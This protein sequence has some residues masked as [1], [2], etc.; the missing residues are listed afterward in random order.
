M[1]KS[2]LGVFTE[3]ESDYVDKSRKRLKII[4]VFCTIIQTG[5][6][7]CSPFIRRT[8]TA[9]LENYTYT[10]SLYLAF[11]IYLVLVSIPFLICRKEL[12]DIRK[13]IRLKLFTEILEIKEKNN[14]VQI[15]VN[16]NSTDAKWIYVSRMLLKYH[17]Y[18]KDDLIVGDKILI[19]I[20]P[21]SRVCIKVKLF[22]SVAYFNR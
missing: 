19:S 4:L 9:L 18:S 12:S 21:N 10:E 5:F 15:K 16:V 11:P 7:L 17:E 13:G 22:I 14:Q 20:L 1:F 2:E 3:L 8:G 6:W